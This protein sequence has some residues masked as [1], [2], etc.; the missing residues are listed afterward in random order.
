MSSGVVSEPGGVVAAVGHAFQLA[1]VVV[2]EGSGGR[3]RIEDLGQPV[4]LVVGELIKPPAGSLNLCDIAVAVVLEFPKA[5]EFGSRREQVV[6]V[7]VGVCHGMIPCVRAGQHAPDGVVGVRV[8]IAQFVLDSRGV[9]VAVV[10]H[11]AGHSVGVFHSGRL[12]VVVV[13]EASLCVRGLDG[14]DQVAV[15][16]VLVCGGVSVGICRFDPEILR[17]EGAGLDISG[18]VFEAGRVAHCVVLECHLSAVGVRIADRPVQP[19]VFPAALV[20]E[21]ID[22]A[23][24]QAL[25]VE[26]VR[27]PVSERID[28][29]RAVASV[30]KHG[31]LVAPVP[32][33]RDPAESVVGVFHED[34]VAGICGFG[35][36]MLFVV[37]VCVGP[38]VGI[39][40][41]DKVPRVVVVELNFAGERVCDFFD[42]S[43]QVVGEVECSSRGVGDRLQVSVAISE[44]DL[45][46]V[47]VRE[48]ADGAVGVEVVDQPGFVGQLK[49]VCDGNQ[50]GKNAR[51]RLVGA[52]GKLGETFG[53]IAVGDVN[54]VFW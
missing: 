36:Q 52:V 1:C 54:R 31:G 14:F 25:V 39:G 12:A 43:V 29:G 5:P 46:A 27:R 48:A 2:A 13:R 16:V 37:C 41:Q 49:A 42:P 30:K 28:N 53:A 8:G 38:A 6:A 19:V 23:N 44:L 7:V 50:L 24:H 22:H 45:V 4:V 47:V 9:A 18:R 33:L 17:V 10:L 40:E 15:G 20:P 11:R 3:I 51:W 21:G 26:Q 32:L 35:D 34:I